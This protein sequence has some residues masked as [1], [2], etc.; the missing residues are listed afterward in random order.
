[1]Q[2]CRH[3]IYYRNIIVIKNPIKVA[4]IDDEDKEQCLMQNANKIAITKVTK[5][6]VS[7]ILIIGIAGQLLMLT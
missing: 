5:N 4:K 6:W 2:I 7:L 3:N 1:M